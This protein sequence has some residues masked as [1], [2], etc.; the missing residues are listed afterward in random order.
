MYRDRRSKLS[1][2]FGN[3]YF[4]WWDNDWQKLHDNG[5]IS[6]LSKSE[7]VDFSSF[8]LLQDNLKFHILLKIQTKIF[9][10]SHV[11]Q[12]YLIIIFYRQN[13]LKKPVQK[14]INLRVIEYNDHGY[15]SKDFL[16]CQLRCKYFQSLLSW[17]LNKWSLSHRDSLGQWNYFYKT[18][19]SQKNSRMK[20]HQFKLQ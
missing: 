4:H 1:Q 8:S 13:S 15:Q 5:T 20:L 14:W 11:I 12:N 6:I 16:S 9:Y 17:Q 18:K 2:I 19:N 3:H 10:W 7:K